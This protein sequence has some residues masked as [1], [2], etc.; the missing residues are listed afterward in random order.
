MDQLQRNLSTRNIESSQYTVTMEDS[1][2]DIS[3]DL[4]NIE[5]G[6]KISFLGG[7]VPVGG[8]ARYLDDKRDSKYDAR[9]SLKFEARTRFEQK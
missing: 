8:S 3:K 2:E 5:A 7:L 4:M 9:V 1:L 6:L